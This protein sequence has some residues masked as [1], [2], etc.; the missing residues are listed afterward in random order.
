[1]SLIKSRN[2]LDEIAGN[3][4]LAYQ[5]GDGAVFDIYVDL[6]SNINYTSV[7]GRTIKI[8]LLDADTT[9]IFKNL[10]FEVAGEIPTAR[11]I[12]SVRVESLGSVV[13]IGYAMIRYYPYAYSNSI[14]QGGTDTRNLEIENLLDDDLIVDLSFSG[15]S[16]INVTF[17][18]TSFTVYESIIENIDF[19][20]D[21]DPTATLGSHTGNILIE[22][23]ASNTSTK[24][25]Y[26]LPVYVNVI[27]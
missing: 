3:A 27:P 16:E 10:P 14:A 22:G 20:V 7:V 21:V 23:E 12:H 13:G 19:T 26:T 18:E 25:N 5:E 15:S 4:K 24:R 11:G 8:V 2:A 17:N 1:V 9:V 6:P